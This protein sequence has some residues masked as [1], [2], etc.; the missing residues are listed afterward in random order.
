MA[1]AFQGKT[2][3]NCHI[4]EI[5]AQ[6]LR[7]EEPTTTRW[8]VCSAIRE[9]PCAQEAEG[10]RRGLRLVFLATA[11]NVLYLEREFQWTLPPQ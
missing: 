10:D 2:Q 11:L 8:R 3:R 4:T 9:P 5:N 7:S 1:R 6:F